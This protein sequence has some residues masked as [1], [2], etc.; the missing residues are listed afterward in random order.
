MLG[1]LFLVGYLITLLLIFLAGSVA[2][3]RAAVGLTNLVFGGLVPRDCDYQLDPNNWGTRLRS[4]N[5]Y[6]IEPPGFGLGAAV[7]LIPGFVCGMIFAVALVSFAGFA[8]LKGGSE[9]VVREAT[10]FAQGAVMLGL[11]P[12][13]VA[14]R[15][16]LV[17]ALLRTTF[18][19]GFVVVVLET[20]IGLALTVG[21]GAALI[22]AGAVSPPAALRGV[23]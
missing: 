22:A 18:V 3:L 20:V 7:V 23:V 9:A 1:L 6:L 10:G 8:F 15:A 13:C 5:A 11:V 16:G 4:P 17:G 14:V 2:V 12:V 19:K 21:I